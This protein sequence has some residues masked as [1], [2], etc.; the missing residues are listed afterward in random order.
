VTPT[1]GVLRSNITPSTVMIDATPEVHE[2]PPTPI[3][4]GHA[5]LKD[6]VYWSESCSLW[7]RDALRRLLHGTVS[8][9]E[10]ESYAAAC[11][12]AYGIGG[13]AVGAL[14][15][16]T[17]GD[18]PAGL[19]DVRTVSLHAISSLAGVNALRPQKPLTF[20]SD[21]LTVI[22]GDNGS[23]KSGY[24]RV[25]RD[26][27][28]ARCAKR[29]VQPDVFE[30][31]PTL[32]SAR[33]EYVVDGQ[34]SATDWHPA[35]DHPRDLSLVSVFDT[36][37]A[38]VYSDDRNDVAYRPFG[39]DLFDK[40]AAV[41]ERVKAVLQEELRRLP[42]ADVSLLAIGPGTKAGAFLQLLTASTDE[43]EI[44][45]WGHV[46]AEQRARH[47]ELAAKIARLKAEDSTQHQRELR[48]FADRLTRLVDVMVAARSSVAD[49]AVADITAARA[50]VT[51]A[52]EALQEF[53][54]ARFEGQSLPGIGSSPWRSLWDA[55][56]RFST[57]AAYVGR[58]FPVTSDSA[59]CVLCLQDLSHDASQ[60]LRDFERFVRADAQTQLDAAAQ[61]VDRYLQALS[62]GVSSEA[63]S[64]IDDLTLRAPELGARIAEEFRAIL[65]RRDAMVS[66]QLPEAL[67]ESAGGAVRSLAS[68]MAEE[69][70][71]LDPSCIMDAINTANAEYSEL[72]AAIKLADRIGDVLSEHRMLSMKAVLERAITET[73]T[74][75]LTRRSTEVTRAVVSDALKQRLTCEIEQLGFGSAPVELM[76]EGGRKGV[77]YHR[78]HLNARQ[79]AKPREVLSEGEFRG[80]ALACFFSEL[81]EE[82]GNPI[83]LDDPVSSLDHVRRERIAERIAAE[84]EK[85]QV[86]IVFTHDLVF[87]FLLKT[88]ADEHEV[89]ASYR[90]LW[91]QRN[92]LGDP[93]D[94]LPLI[95]QNVKER[96][97]ALKQKQQELRRIERDMPHQFEAEAR[98]FC[99]Q[100][101]MTW[102]RAIEEVAF[103]D[104]V[105]RFRTT[106]ET[107]RLKRLTF[108]PEDYATIERGMQ[109]CSD[110]MHDQAEALN[111]GCP[112]ADELLRWVEELDEWAKQVKARRGK[113]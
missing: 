57:D 92:I 56:R 113:K 7:Q 39:L 8:D 26:V 98:M 38:A 36:D 65:R 27:C 70:S 1:G 45:K 58:V 41:C 24:V 23:G 83:V 85:R 25:L 55:A 2:T 88:A 31:Q 82:A 21:G 87:L 66:D 20:A 86:V 9:L 102:E 60:R 5:L 76:D 72:D 3:P 67:P 110:W 95:A 35:I 105:R 99:V 15:P 68:Q 107:V 69:A 30:E 4:A 77:F 50:K 28:R 100:L 18:V 19:S 33:I 97:G 109:K 44:R 63:T 84:A 43:R 80:I 61:Q 11:K 16:I 53:S 46:S 40:L 71:R 111:L 90:H 29:A 89:P 52:T 42:A 93:E 12:S 47:D 22:Y 73:D 78:I 104:A 34:S 103:N 62:T 91:S 79:P 106:V 96:L 64:L 37:C 10:I 48:F 32:P 17:I 94:G 6:I 81:P 14:I 49:S 59:K 108:G 101:R 51:A 112:S 54:A 13:G 75:R 74:Q